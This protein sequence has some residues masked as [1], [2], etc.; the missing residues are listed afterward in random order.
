V[1][2]SYCSDADK[3]TFATLAAAFAD[4]ADL[5]FANLLADDDLQRL[6]DKHHCH[7]GYKANA[8]YS[9]AL[10]L[11]AF[12]AQCLSASKTCTAAVARVL[13]LITASGG[14]PPSAN[15][16]AFCKA[17]GKLPVAMLQ[18]LTTDIGRRGSGRGILSRWSMAPPCRGPT[19][20]RTSA[21]IP[22]HARKRRG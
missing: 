19:P 4:A 21:N 6:A 9:V 14:A 11:W 12:L 15:N 2:F 13:V 10:T 3:P 22:N 16:G 5:P 17:R 8:T 1:S 18:E 7:F 20:Q